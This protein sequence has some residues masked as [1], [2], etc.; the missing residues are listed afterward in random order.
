M[1]YYVQEESDVAVYACKFKMCS[2]DIRASILVYNL[3][4]AR[5]AS[6]AIL[7]QLE[8]NLT[9]L[10]VLCSQLAIV[11]EKHYT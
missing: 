9:H 10:H 4:V 2:R 3:L 7:T 5:Y 11:I 1:Y 8:A 6:Q